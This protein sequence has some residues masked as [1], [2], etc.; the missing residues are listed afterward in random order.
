MGIEEPHSEEGAV[1]QKM[2]SG[3]ARIK[4]RFH[5]DDDEIEEEDVDER[6]DK[7]NKVLYI[8]LRLFHCK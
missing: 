4:K 8:K 2:G 1:D 7:N 3:S 6:K 5:D